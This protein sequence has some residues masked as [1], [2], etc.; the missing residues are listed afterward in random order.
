MVHVGNGRWTVTWQPQRTNSSGTYVATVTAFEA[1]SNG[2]VFGNQVDIPVTLTARGDVPIVGSGAIFN[3]ASFTSNAPVA[4]GGLIT[5][6]GSKLA[7]GSPQAGELPLPSQ[8]SGTQVLL[9]NT[10]LPLLY[11]SDGQINAQVPYDIAINVP[12]QLVVR[13][14][15]ALSVPQMVSVAPAQP[16]VFTKDQSGHGQGVIVNGITNQ[17]ADSAAPVTTGDTVVIYCTGLGAV[18]PPTPPGTGITG[19]TPT[20]QPVTVTIGDHPAQVAFAGLTGGFA[21]VYQ[22]NAVL[23]GGITPGSSVP[24][25]IST[26]GQSSP[27]VTIAVR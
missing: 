24:V 5:I 17:L 13:R 12:N 2:S 23:P 6:F 8:L 16:A 1:L 18:N 4:P 15:N 20:V 10:S 3:A 26:A 25:V 9:G 21:G 22:V 14:G 7:D 27:A 19:P 11:A